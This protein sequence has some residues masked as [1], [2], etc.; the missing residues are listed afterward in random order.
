METIC[1]KAKRLLEPIP[2]EKIITSFLVLDDGTGCPE[3]WLNGL[4]VGE[5]A[6]S[7]YNGF[8]NMVNDHIRGFRDYAY[9]SISWAANGGPSQ[10]YIQPTP[11][12]R[13]MALLDD[14]IAAGL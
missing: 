4:D 3:G 11:K 7:R 9:C 10:P 5:D 8:A 12:E 13:A 2:S 14:C 1:Q 6:P